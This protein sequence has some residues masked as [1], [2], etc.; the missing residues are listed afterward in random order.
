MDWFPDEPALPA[1]QR[2]AAD[3]G[4]RYED[5]TQDGRLSIFALPHALGDVVWRSL[6]SGVPWVHQANRTGIVPVLTRFVLEAGGGPISVRAPLRGAGGYQLAHT[7]GGDG[8]PDRALFN[9]WVSLTAPR[10]RTHGPPPDRAGEMIPVGRVFAEHVFTRPFAPPSERK[11]V[12]LPFEG[13]PPSL[14]WQWRPLEAVLEPPPSAH[15]LDEE[16]VADE[17]PIRCGLDHTDS[18]QHVNSLVYPRLF[19][20]AALRRF[21]AHGHSTSLIARRLEIAYRKPSFAGD[22]LRIRLA[23]FSDGNSL[24]AVGT[25]VADD[26]PDARPRCAVQIRFT[27]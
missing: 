27:R 20:E 9:L 6:L 22:R 8:A 12:Q 2:G 10:G 5:V 21:A 13:L 18:N 16:M 7:V 3:S 23:A 25:W 14:P 15:L 4:L 11:V 24:G 26:D 17:A 19:V 1:A